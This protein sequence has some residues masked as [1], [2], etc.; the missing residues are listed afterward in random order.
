MRSLNQNSELA[1]NNLL[2]LDE[3]KID[4]DIY[5]DI[6]CKEISTFLRL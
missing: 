4:K 3:Y 5:V 1:N 6:D 2:K